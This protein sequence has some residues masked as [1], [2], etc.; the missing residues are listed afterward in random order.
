MSSIL[1]KLF[2]LLLPIAV[3]IIAEV[4]ARS[5]ATKEAREAFYKFVDAMQKSPNISAALKGSYEEQLRRLNAS[6]DSSGPP[7]A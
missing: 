7:Q 3:K 5:Q 6:K 2:E 1:P 4:L